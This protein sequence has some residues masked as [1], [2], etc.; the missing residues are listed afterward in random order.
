MLR[1]GGGD[2]RKLRGLNVPTGSRRLLLSMSAIQSRFG[3]SEELFKLH[4][5]ALEQPVAAAA[6]Q[7]AGK[8][9]DISKVD[10]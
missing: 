5:E 3:T 6:T 10:G 4:V 7:L 9:V 1:G 2:W 8:N